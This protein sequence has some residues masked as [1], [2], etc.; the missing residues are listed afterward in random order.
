MS[1]NLYLKF[2]F[3]ILFVGLPLIFF[4]NLVAIPKIAALLGMSLFTILVLWFDNRHDFSQ[5]FNRPD[6]SASYGGLIRRSVVVGI[7]VFGL[8]VLLHPDALFAFPRQDP[9]VW[10]VV[11]LLYPLLSA[12]PQELIYREFFFQRYEKLF[13]SEQM[14]GIASAVAFSALH[15]IYDN[16]WAIGLSL[17]GGFMFVYTYLRSK[18]LYWVS[19]EH[20]IYGCLVFTIGM[21]QYFYEAF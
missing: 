20:A 16:W 18:S 1:S 8:V 10:M 19:V 14:L 3:L 2:E 4:F 7:A 15:I 9:V 11:M 6:K 17:I 21:G 13:P 5:L 12:L